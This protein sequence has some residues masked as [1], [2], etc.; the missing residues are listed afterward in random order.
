MPEFTA[1][2]CRTLREALP[3]M[4]IPVLDDARL[5]I[6]FTFAGTPI[7]PVSGGIEPGEG[8]EVGSGGTD[9]D[10]DD[11]GDDQGEPGDDDGEADDDEP[12]GEP[13][14][15]AL[16][17]E[18]ERADREKDKARQARDA[19]KPFTDL[20]KRFGSIEDIKA[21]LE[22]KVKDEDGREVNVA[23]LRREIESEISGKYQT[24]LNDSLIEK[25][26]AESFQRPAD[27]LAFLD[28]SALEPGT[29]GKL[30]EQEVREALATVLTDRPYLGKTAPEKKRKQLPGGR[31]QGSGREQNTGGG[32]VQSGREAYRAFVDSSKKSA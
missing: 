11:T 27:A 10:E 8:E 7:Y 9:D 21:R 24:Q 32:S 13:G 30:D 2:R 6:L 3:H 4:D 28:R 31:G 26:A 22:G 5:P 1:A 14:R 25:L 19:L 23:D 20:T 29:D 16:Q 12:L 18:R 15:K 17:A